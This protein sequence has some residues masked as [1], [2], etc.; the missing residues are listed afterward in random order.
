MDLIDFEGAALSERERLAVDYTKAAA[1]DSNNIPAALSAD[2]KQAFP[3]PE[4]VELSFLI[5]F[6]N[7]LNL[8]NNLMLVRYHGE[9]RA[10][11]SA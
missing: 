3:D 2:I 8:F 4:I 11:T 1:V 7:M 10:L 5:G 6:I 9:Y